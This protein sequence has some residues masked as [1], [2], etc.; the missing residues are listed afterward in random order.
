MKKYTYFWAFLKTGLC[1][2]K[3][4]SARQNVTSAIIHASALKLD[5]VID[6]LGAGDCFIGA[7]LHFLN[8]GRS[9]SEVLRAATGIAGV[10]CGQKGLLNIDINNS[11]DLV[12]VVLK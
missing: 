2:I 4:A 3:G 10:K 6:T 5:N 1:E 12:E 11:I 7:S 9:L 8:E